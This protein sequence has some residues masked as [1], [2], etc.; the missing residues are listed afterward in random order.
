VKDSWA[1]AAAYEAIEVSSRRFEIYV[2][3]PE[4]TELEVSDV[5]DEVLPNLAGKSMQ[6]RVQYLRALGMLRD[7]PTD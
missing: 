5:E 6:S 1:S 3:V 7:R 4:G 2:Y